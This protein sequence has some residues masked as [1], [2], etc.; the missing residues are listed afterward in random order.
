MAL[1]EQD[2]LDLEER[3]AAAPAIAPKIWF[4]SVRTA[5]AAIGERSGISPRSWRFLRAPGFI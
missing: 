4:R 5:R 2:V 3:P 1:G